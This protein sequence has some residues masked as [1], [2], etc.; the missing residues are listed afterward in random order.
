MINVSN[1][2]LI[3]CFNDFE[4]GTELI[5]TTEKVEVY[6]AETKDLKSL[7]PAFRNYVS[8]DES[9][10]AAKFF[11][12]TE[13]ETYITCHSMLRIMLSGKISMK[14]E[15]VPFLKSI[16]NKPCL[17]GNQVYFN[18]S[19]T[20]TAFAI[21]LS[22]NNPLGVDIED[23]E[24]AVDIHSVAGSYFSKKEYAYTMRTVAGQKKRFFL[25]WTRKEALL[26]ALG[27]G[28]IDDLNK[29]EVSDKENYFNPE[30][31]NKAYCGSQAGNYF[32]YSKIVAGHLLSLAIPVNQAIDFIP[33]NTSYVKSLLD[34]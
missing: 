19:H 4:K 2:N 6:F 20:K 9:S 31:L 10:R 25:V 14:P 11:S 23:M 30:L 8:D 27:T 15:D 1:Y 22:M 21:G 28:I 33:L 3:R 17:P 32:I 13:R 16:N 18:I 34:S 26:K 12:D 5:N 7:Y 29:V 24:R